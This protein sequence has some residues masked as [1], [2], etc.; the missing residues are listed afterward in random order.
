MR[1]PDPGMSGYVL[2]T[3]FEHQSRVLEL[4]SR[5]IGDA[6]LLFKPHWGSGLYKPVLKRLFKRYKILNPHKDISDYFKGSDYLLMGY[7]SNAMWQGLE[8]G[9]PTVIIEP[10]D[11]RFEAADFPVYSSDVFPIVRTPERLRQLLLEGFS[12]PKDPYY[13]GKP[14]AIANVASIVRAAPPPYI[15]YNSSKHLKEVAIA[16][17]ALWLDREFH[18]K[19]LLFCLKHGLRYDVR[20]LDSFG[21]YLDLVHPGAII[22]DNETQKDTTHLASLAKER[23]IPTYCVSHAT[24]QVKKDHKPDLLNKYST[25]L[26]HSDFDRDNYIKRGWEGEKIIVTG[27]PRYDSLR[28]KKIKRG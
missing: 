20:S 5:A 21:S 14:N 11:S 6:E 7:F 22:M 10:E 17:K 28:S 15:V 23:G 9:L 27:T 3:K 16:L 12:N 24:L 25:M 1:C 8:V 2:A 4:V 19:H 26:A 13:L 18:Q